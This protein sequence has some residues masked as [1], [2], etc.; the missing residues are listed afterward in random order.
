MNLPSI[1]LLLPALLAAPLLTA[2]GNFLPSPV[3]L[4]STPGNGTLPFS[5]GTGTRWQQIHG[6]V[7]GPPRLI[8]GL[9]LR[10]DEILPLLPP[11]TAGAIDIEVLVGEGDRNLVSSDFAQNFLVPAVQV[12]PPGQVFLPNWTTPNGGPQAFDLDVPFA[13]PFAYSGQLDLVVEVRILN[14]P[15]SAH[16]ADAYS[17]DGSSVPA[18]DLG[19][20]CTA[21]FLPFRLDASL[22]TSFVPPLQAQIE[23]DLRALFAPAGLPGFFLIGAQN[24]PVSLPGLCTTLFPSI[25]VVVP[26]TQVNVPPIAINS[27]APLQTPFVPS[28][29]GA[30]VT[31]Q[32]FAIDVLQPGLPFVLSQ[33]QELTV[34]A[35]PPTPLPVVSLRGTLAAPLADF[36]TYGGRVLE[37]E[38]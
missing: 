8:R 10:R 34:A 32:A 14:D 13:V 17:E 1:L 38:F 12:L 6:D 25:D 3:Q 5:F 4:Q 24:S 35:L 16:F 11:A 28:L 23:W 36:V 9:R 21:G 18:V 33:G 27:A 15:N 29:V 2:Q 20:G 22:T 31:V 19:V 37:F 26:A 30:T 7:Q